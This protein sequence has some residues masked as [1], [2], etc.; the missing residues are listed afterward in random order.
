MKT[1]F[2]TLLPIT[3][4]V[5]LCSLT[6]ACPSSLPD[7]RSFLT[8]LPDSQKLNTLGL[9][10]THDSATYDIYILAAQTQLKTITEQLNGGIRA[11]D[12]RVRRTSNVFAMHHDL[13]Y[14]GMMFGDIVKQVRDFLKSNPNELVIM[15]MQEEY[16]AEGSTMDECEILENQYIKENG[17]LFVQHWSVEDTI[18][19][20]RGKI[21][22]ARAHR[23]FWGCTTSLNCEEQNQWKITFSFTRTDKWNAIAAFQDKIFE[24]NSQRS[25]YIN[26]MSAHGGIIGPNSI[27]NKF[28]KDTRES[29]GI[30]GNPGMNYRMTK[31]FR[32][33]KNTLY[34][35]MADNP[36]PQ[37]VDKIVLSNF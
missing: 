34:I 12:M 16:T 30:E 26:Y 18:G 32:N 31:Y 10:G 6:M 2:K 37:L 22:L 13:I 14:L 33:P 23:G 29:Q 25:C 36:L 19:Q 20:H 8:K 11:L 4:L 27:A 28:W 24:E 35:V 5:S 1:I 9:I 3:I 21:L 17:D 15:F 7:H